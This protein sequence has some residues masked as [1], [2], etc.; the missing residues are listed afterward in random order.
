MLKSDGAHRIALFFVTGLV[1][2]GKII[3]QHILGAQ[4]L[5]YMMAKELINTP[6]RKVTPV[7]Q[8]FA[9]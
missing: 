1:E 2:G 4:Q 8:A 3:I 5:A 7:I 6:F 9:A